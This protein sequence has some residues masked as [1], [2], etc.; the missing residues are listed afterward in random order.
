[1]IIS[2]Y[3]YNFAQTDDNI[4]NKLS[5]TMKKL[6][7]LL[8]LALFCL[9][10]CEKN[11]TPQEPVD[12]TTSVE[13]LSEIPMTIA[14]QGG[15]SLILFEIK[16]PV[17]G[18]RVTAYSNAFWVKD[19]MANDGVVSFVADRNTTSNRREGVI[20][21]K[22]GDI[23]KYV[24][25]IQE[26]RP[27]GEYDYETVATVFGGEYLGNAGED[28]YNYYVQLGTGEINE[29]NNGANAVYYYF[30]IY[31][32]NRGGEHPILANG[33]YEFDRNNSCYVGTF[34]A[35]HSKAHFNDGDGQPET[36]F[37]M[38]SGT[39]TVTDNKFEAIVTMSDG[40]LHRIVYE[41]ELY[42]PS[43]V[44]SPAYSSKLTED[45]TFDLSTG[46]LRLFYYGDE[47]GI[48]ADYW[49]IALMED[50]G[51][52]N[53]AYFQIKLFTDSCEDASY[54]SLAGVYTPCSDLAPQ[55]NCFIKGLVEG[56][57]YVG[58][59]YYVVENYVINNNL[60]APIYDGQIE[61]AV[62]GNDVSVTLDCIDDNGHKI[63]GSFSSVGIEFYDRRGK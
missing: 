54:D 37:E 31:A 9:S 2:D 3:F 29:T 30:D 39:V 22:Y 10:A 19:V 42:V 44:E 62:D 55:K 21:I 53:G 23:E 20:T 36:S 33:T 6:F 50:S 25:L 8:A 58:S 40:T 48:G 45:F 13:V 14:Y 61:I 57:M 43:V 4:N 38:K 63:Q 60:G 46:Y 59:Q 24:G 51:A 12:T 18:V 47:Y 34:T 35:E 41:G 28:N 15:K 27:E 49:S 26:V 56:V 11:E 17:E 52:R 7:T 5:I 16:N 1:M 32:K